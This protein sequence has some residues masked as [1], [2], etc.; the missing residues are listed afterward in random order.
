MLLLFSSSVGGQAADATLVVPA[1][2]AALSRVDRAPM[3]EHEAVGVPRARSRSA[4]LPLLNPLQ[5]DNL[6]LNL[7]QLALQGP[8]LRLRLPHR[9]LCLL[10][11]SP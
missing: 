9:C 2:D 8:V 7:L 11:L 1:F 10:Q 4:Q 5:L 3:A 6:L